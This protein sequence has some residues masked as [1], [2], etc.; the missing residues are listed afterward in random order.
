MCLLNGDIQG[1]LPMSIDF[2]KI[3]D[4]GYEYIEVSGKKDWENNEYCTKDSSTGKYYKVSRSYYNTYLKGTPL[5]QKTNP[6]TKFT[7]IPIKEIIR[8]AV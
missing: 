2:G 8:N 4:V 7:Q 3:E 6:Y 5:Y 1:S